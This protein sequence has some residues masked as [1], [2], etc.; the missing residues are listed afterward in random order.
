MSKV[1]EQ[2]MQEQEEEFEEELSYQEYLRDNSTE[3]NS[4]EIMDMA[5]EILRPTLF[6]K[7][8]WYVNAKN[9]TDYNPTITTGA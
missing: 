7:F 6:S 2:M 4:I 9:N 1:K 5:R 8:Y 3:P